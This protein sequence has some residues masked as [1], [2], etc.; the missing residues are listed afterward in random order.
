MLVKNLTSWAGEN[1][2]YMP[3]DEIEIDDATAIARCEAG[4]A[5]ASTEDLAAARQ[6]IAGPAT[7]AKPGK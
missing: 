4:L 7:K 3:G 5:S 6:R 1:F 2:S